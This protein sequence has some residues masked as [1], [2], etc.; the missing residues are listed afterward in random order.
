MIKRLGLPVEVLLQVAADTQ[1][2]L[3]TTGGKQKRAKLLAY[4]KTIHDTHKMCL[5]NMTD[6]YGNSLSEPCAKD[7]T[8][9]QKYK[10]FP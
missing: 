3:L 10:L 9:H 4:N 5:Q 6:P 2:S 7:E 8:I 1:F